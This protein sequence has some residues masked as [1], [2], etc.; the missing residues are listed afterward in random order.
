MEHGDKERSKGLSF[1]FFE[2]VLFMQHLVKRPVIKP[3]DPSQLAGGIKQL[4]EL[5]P[6]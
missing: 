5:G 1:L 3:V 4:M 2:P 6:T